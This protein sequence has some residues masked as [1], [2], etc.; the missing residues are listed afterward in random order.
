MGVIKVVVDL[1]SSQLEFTVI[2]NKHSRMVRAIIIEAVCICIVCVLLCAGLWP[3]HTP[4]ND[5]TWLPNDNGL[6]F[7][8][9]G[10]IVSAST[11]PVPIDR[12]VGS[13]EL[14]LE[15]ALLRGRHTIL[16]FDGSAHPGAPFSLFQIKDALIVQQDN[17]D[18]NGISWTAWCV[19]NGAFRMRK[20]VFVTVTMAP[21]Q[22][23]VY[24]D[25]VSNRDCARGDSWN[26]FTGRLVVANS[27]SAS[28]SWPG[29]IR[30]MAI[31]DRELTQGEI[32]EQYGNWTKNRRPNI[33]QEQA[34]IA[35]YLFN[36]G[37]GHTVHNEFDS[38][39]DLNIPISYFVLHPPFLAPPWR[40]Y[41]TTWE[42]WEDVI[43]NVVGFIPFGF[44][45]FAYFSSVRHMRRAAL[46]TIFL[47]FLLSL[48]IETLQA[49]LP[50]RDSG[51]NDLITNT[52]GTALGVVMC[53]LAWPE[54][55]LGKALHFCSS[56]L[57][58]SRK[59]EVAVGFASH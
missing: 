42:Y 8:R 56:L 55:T 37:G 6:H 36:E 40:N 39:T 57:D 38:K 24:L 22:T 18:T 33:A 59:E 35:L 58:D 51:M 34:P 44:C 53:N 7:G 29:K 52:L 41:Q 23:A 2:G 9:L 12:T 45:A 25:G 3:F 46:V 31:Y 48:I 1:G 26:N 47:G 27:P 32:L 50:T 4:K 43:V 54:R 10:S 49:F 21:R 30:G 16:S 15:P 19:V 17:E 28:D 5:V 13:I 20:P 14:W 11:F